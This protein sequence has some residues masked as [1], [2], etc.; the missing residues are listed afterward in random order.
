M[1]G[2]GDR[3]EH[4]L[5]WRGPGGRGT[6]SGHSEE[7]RAGERFG[8]VSK[9][10]TAAWQSH[11]VDTGASGARNDRR[12][13]RGGR[14]VFPET[15]AGSPAGSRGA[16]SV[17]LRRRDRIAATDAAIRDWTEGGVKGAGDSGG[18][19][20]G[21]SRAEFTGS[22]E[23]RAIVSLDAGD[24]AERCGEYSEF[25]EICFQEDGSADVECC[26]GGGVF[27]IARRPQRVRFAIAFCTGPFC[28]AWIEESAGARI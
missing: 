20:S 28:R 16:G 7:W 22:F 8:C 19:R 9:A 25:A 1:R 6:L 15:I 27:E 3:E 11:G 14:R 18:R 21:R 10:G 13:A 2:G 5:Q 4:R 17:S 23:H 12:G 26:G 24:F